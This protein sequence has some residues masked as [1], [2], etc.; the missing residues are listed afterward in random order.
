[1]NNYEHGKKGKLHVSFFLK[2]KIT[3]TSKFVQYA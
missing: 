2:V 1:M 3:K